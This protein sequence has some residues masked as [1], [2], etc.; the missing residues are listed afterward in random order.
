MRCAEFHPL[1]NTPLGTNPPT[2]DYAR[3]ESEFLGVAVE[4]YRKLPKM[5]ALIQECIGFPPFAHTLQWEIGMTVFGWGTWLDY[6][7]SVAGHCE[8]YANV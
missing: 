8:N 3:V 5:G 4:F 1:L 2:A 6:A 7:Y